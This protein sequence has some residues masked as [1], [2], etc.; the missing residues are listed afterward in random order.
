ML[1]TETPA[2]PRRAAPM[3][4]GAWVAIAAAVVGVGLLLT[5]PLAHAV[6]HPEN[7]LARWFEDRRTS[8]LTT[9]AHVF[10][11]PGDTIVVLALATLLAIGLL[12]MRQWLSA[13]FVA[14]AVGGV[15]GI[16]VLGFTLAHRD[17][18]PVKILD[19]GLVP[20]HSFPSGHVAA[21]TV[22]WGALVVLARAYL[23]S[24]ARWLVPVL[25][26]LPPLVLVSR[27]YLGAHHLRSRVRGAGASRFG[28]PSA[29]FGTFDVG[30]A[31]HCA[32]SGGA[33]T[34]AATR[35]ITTAAACR[36]IRAILRRSLAEDTEKDRFVSFVF[37]GDLRVLS[38]YNLPTS[39]GGASCDS[40]LG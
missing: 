39:I 9:T 20:N 34:F 1:S 13:V 29:V 36:N 26:V 3:L 7:D 37:S 11:T 23:P 15:Y 18:P 8:T 22:L 35:T 38:A 6:G 14:L 12:V 40:A 21:A 30:K 32:E 16:Y 19:P 5:H 10:T 28:L 4:V 33:S 25:V 2:P 31:G 17:R 24:V 27:L